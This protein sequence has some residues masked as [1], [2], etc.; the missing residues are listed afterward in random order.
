MQNGRPSNQEATM[1]ET[2]F[3]CPAAQKRHREGPLAHARQQFLEDCE[4]RGYSRTMLEKIAWVLLSLAP[5]VDSKPGRLTTEDIDLAIDHRT[6]FRRS[7]A[8]SSGGSS[9]Y[10]LFRHFGIAWARSMGRF[11]DATKICRFAE[12]LN[13]FENHMLSERGLSPVTIA[14]CRERLTWLFE[15]LPLRR[16]L[17]DISITDIDEFISKKH[18]KGW[19]RH[20]LGAL[21][22]SLRCFFRYAES[23][24][25]CATGLAVGIEGPRLYEREGIP[26]GPPWQ[27]VQRLLESIR[28][29]RPVDIRDHAILLL[30]ALYGLRRGEV[31]HLRLDDLD[32]EGESI[33]VLRPKQRYIQ[34]YPLLRVVGDAI[35][36]YLRE[37][38]PR[39]AHRQLFMALHSPIRPLSA[40]SVS[41]VAAS[42][43][44]AI[45]VTLRPHGAHCLRHA[46]ASHLLASGFSLKQIGD[47][48][49]HRDAKSTLSYT[50]VDLKGLRQVADIDLGRLLRRSQKLSPPTS[51]TSTP[52]DIGSVL[53][54]PF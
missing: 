11:E 32:W 10:Q 52:W 2:L 27:D 19:T 23:Q 38:R 29:D 18:G 53:K 9:S 21:T 24:G 36:R 37:A 31:A 26:E 30:L 5:A 28:G 34:R 15:E 49:G 51:R 16:R 43:L 39:T 22:G 1:F 33:C 8:R 40:A 47:H 13:S 20:S 41:A 48:L 44:T 45:G 54:P 12:Y 4:R 3:D 6:K 25:W 42:R 46:C 17:Q 7:P 35:L 50:K 14:T